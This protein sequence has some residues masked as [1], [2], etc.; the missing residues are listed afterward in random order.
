[1]KLNQSG[2]S[3]SI[4]KIIECKMMNS[5]KEITCGFCQEKL[6]TREMYVLMEVIPQFTKET[7]VET[8]CIECA[9]KILNKSGNDIEN[10]ARLQMDKIRNWKK[11]YG[12]YLESDTYN[13]LKLAKS[14]GEKDE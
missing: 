9:D 10:W 13:K 8:I 12:D 5:N 3:S 4:G 7:K 2:P 11:M 6:M 14:L 1:M